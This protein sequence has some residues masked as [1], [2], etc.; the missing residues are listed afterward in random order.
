MSEEHRINRK[1]ERLLGYNSFNEIRP[2]TKGALFSEIQ[3]S[4]YRINHYV[5]QN[6]IL[7]EDDAKP[8]GVHFLKKDKFFRYK[9]RGNIENK[10]D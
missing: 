6:K 4:E 2:D 8:L 10:I 9:S 1:M 5:K 3:E 7:D